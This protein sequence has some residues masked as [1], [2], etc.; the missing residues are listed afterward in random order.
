MSTVY[1]H[2]ICLL[3]QWLAGSTTTKHIV[4][5]LQEK[6]K[7]HIEAELATIINFSEFESSWSKFQMRPKGVYINE[8][9]NSCTMGFIQA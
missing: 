9:G 1:S 8:H 5:D 3:Y 4:W 2:G 7:I 6:A